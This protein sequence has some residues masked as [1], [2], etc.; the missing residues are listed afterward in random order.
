M[1]N[2]HEY[3]QRIAEIHES[4]LIPGDYEIS[5]GL[6]LQVECLALFEAELD[7]FGRPSLL[8]AKTL[9]SWK[10]MKNA[11]EKSGVVIQIISAWRSVDYQ[12]GIFERKLEAGQKIKDILKVNAAPGYSEHHTGRALDIGTEGVEHLSEAFEE[13]EAFSWLEV[14]AEN[15]GFSLSFPRNNSANILYEPWHW[16]YSE[17]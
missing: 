2:L 17:N 11:A 3:S 9:E 6:G 10:T 5:C 14:N 4:L 16:K 7:V 8:E 1:E 15:F 13:S 12:K